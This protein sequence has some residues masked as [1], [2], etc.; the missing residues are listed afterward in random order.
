MTVKEPTILCKTPTPGKK[1]TRIAKWKYDCVRKALLKCAP[2][3]KIGIAFKDM[4]KLVEKQLTSE[5]RRTLGSVTWYTVTV[6]LDMEVR[7]ELSR[8]PNVSPQRIRRK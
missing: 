1:G 6:K 4:P 2:K 8:I 5:E 3:N 7:G